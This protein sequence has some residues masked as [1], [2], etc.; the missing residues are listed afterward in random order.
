MTVIHY[1]SHCQ[2]SVCSDEWNMSEWARRKCCSW[3]WR[4][5]VLNDQF[6]E[7]RQKLPELKSLEKWNFLHPVSNGA[8]LFPRWGH[9]DG[10]WRRVPESRGS[11]RAGRRLSAGTLPGRLQLHEPQLRQVTSCTHMLTLKKLTCHDPHASRQIPTKKLL[12]SNFLSQQAAAH[13]HS[14]KLPSERRSSHW[15]HA[16][17]PPGED[18]GY[19]QCMVVVLLVKPSKIIVLIILFLQNIWEYLDFVFSN[20]PA[21]VCWSVGVSAV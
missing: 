2:G 19:K 13:S 4:L 9:N 16:H 15:R 7:L 12:N 5:V 11:Q 8:S 18:K 1:L 14:P 3:N 6:S 10:W 17:K 21:D 20:W